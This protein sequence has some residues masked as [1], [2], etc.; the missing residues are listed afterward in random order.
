[1]GVVEVGFQGRFLYD[2]DMRIRPPFWFILYDQFAVSRPDSRLVQFENSPIFE[3]AT[4][5]RINLALGNAQQRSHQG[6]F[7]AKRLLDNLTFSGVWVSWIPMARNQPPEF[8]S[9]LNKA[10]GTSRAPCSPLII[11]RI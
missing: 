1:M 11:L 3:F 7:T 2:Y 9:S 4:S 10:V 8:L 6:N 5:D